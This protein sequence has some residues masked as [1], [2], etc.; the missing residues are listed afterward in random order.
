MLKDDSAPSV[1]L[2]NIKN[3]AILKKAL[4]ELVYNKNN[5]GNSLLDLVD[6]G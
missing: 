1:P 5:K 6:L 4:N 3:K 2:R